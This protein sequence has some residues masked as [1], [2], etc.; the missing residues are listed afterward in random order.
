[1]CAVSRK[2]G[3]ATMRSTILLGAC[4]LVSTLAQAAPPATQPADPTYGS[5]IARLGDDNPHVRDAAVRDLRKAGR[6]ALGALHDAAK[7]SNP[8][9]RDS[10]EML[11]AEAEGKR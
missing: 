9:V 7:S 8:Q 5:M 6:E 3:E 11:V 4:L 10:A 1:M 2:R